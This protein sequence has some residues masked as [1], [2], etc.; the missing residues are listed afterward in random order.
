MASSSLGRP[1][2]TLWSAFSAANLGD[3]VT[4]VAFP[5]LAVSLTDDARL[6]A[7]VAVARF[8]PFVVIG[9][10]AGLVLDR[11][12]RK[13]VTAAAQVGRS[14]ALVLLA[15][16]SLTDRA[17]I[18]TL[19]I[20][21]F[22]VGLGE[23]LTDGGVPALVRGVVRP[24]MLEV[25][26]SRISA[27]QTVSNMF[28]G[29]PIGAVMF[30][31]DPSV[32]FIFCAAVFGLGAIALLV[33]PGKHR[34]ATETERGSFG[35]EL[36]VG[37]RYVWQHPVLRPLAMNVAVFA[38]AGEAVNAVLVILATE[39]L[40]LGSLGFGL[41]LSL[42]AIMSITMSFF[43][44]R[45]VAKIGHGGSMRISVITFSAAAFLLGTSTIVAVA[46]VAMLL[47]GISDP[48]WNVVSSTIRQ[49]LVPDEV[50]GR[51]MTAYLV[52]AWC[53]Q[54]F[55][56]MMGGFVA[57]AWGPEWVYLIS[58]TLVASL[59]IFARPMFA[60]VNEAMAAAT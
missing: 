6:V 29:P 7:A 52:I 23:V 35:A 8:L 49:R 60:K 39:R 22:L 48:T 40:G 36:T 2:W 44:A 33:L 43:I 27:T 42:D 5:L 19:L 57:E 11:F 4:Y 38:F 34:P 17:G 51:M 31:I 1:F 14:L 54:P 37:L 16:A 3:G 59:T 47:G 30:E 28:I 56:I 24:E 20:I 10:P 9:L 46:A 32:A 25:A 13:L 12:D 58:G 21:G 41:L 15:V 45:L 50:F 18:G 55:G 26:N 53:L